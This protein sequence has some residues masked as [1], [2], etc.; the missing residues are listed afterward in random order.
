LKAPLEATEK[1]Q[2]RSGLAN[3]G[4]EFQLITLV[5]GTLTTAGKLLAPLLFQASLIGHPS[6]PI[7][8]SLMMDMH[9]GILPLAWYITGRSQREFQEFPKINILVQPA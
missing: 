6:N 7:G 5:L 1:F 2:D 4:Q 8:L 3:Q 9:L